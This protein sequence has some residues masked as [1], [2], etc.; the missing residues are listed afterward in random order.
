M[1]DVAQLFYTP[2]LRG[3]R[4]GWN[5]IGVILPLTRLV[6]AEHG[7][8]CRAELCYRSVAVSALSEGHHNTI[9]L[10]VTAC[11]AV[12]CAPFDLGVAREALRFGE[13][14]RLQRALGVLRATASVCSRVV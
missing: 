4:A 8:A 7:A 6:V 13:H 9:V 2:T 3:R 11:M 5:I 1:Q 10:Q 12:L 14:E